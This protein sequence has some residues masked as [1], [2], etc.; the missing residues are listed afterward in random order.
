[1]KPMVEREIKQEIKQELKHFN[2]NW[3]NSK[4]SYQKTKQILLIF[5]KEI[6]DFIKN[7]F[8][9]FKHSELILKNIHKIMK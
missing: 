7:K 3:F 5:F 4:S 8:K 1:M 2:T 9:N 6:V